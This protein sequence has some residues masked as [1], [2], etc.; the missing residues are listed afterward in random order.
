MMKNFLIFLKWLLHFSERHKDFADI[1]IKTV[2][3]LATIIGAFFVAWKYF[4]DRK[5]ARL[6]AELNLRREAYFDL[7]TAIP[8]QMAE[9]SKLFS[10]ENK[11]VGPVSEW[12]T[13]LHRLHLL[14]NG[15]ALKCVITRTAIYH[16]GLFDLLKLKSEALL[17]DTLKTQ[18]ETR[19]AT[20]QVMELAAQKR[21]EAWE[22]LW[23]RLRTAIGDLNAN[24]RQLVCLARAEIGLSS[25]IDD[26][27]FSM[28]EDEKLAFKEFDGILQ[29]N[30][31]Q[32][33]LPEVPPPL[34]C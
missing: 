4:S 23:A 5:Q 3:L 19:G 21:A 28:R 9:I 17:A 29:V 7:F 11:V 1:C 32:Y 27:I 6:Q 12:F 30:R 2:G 16:I 14:A 24:Y 15:D 10:L 33:G 31:R 25:D 13:A 20:Q 26:I 8:L 22:A 34:S 18:L